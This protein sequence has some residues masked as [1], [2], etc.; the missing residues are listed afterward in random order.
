MQARKKKCY[1]ND[2]TGPTHKSSQLVDLYSRQAL[3]RGGA[4]Q[5]LR[6]QWGQD[7]GAHLMPMPLPREVSTLGSSGRSLC[8]LVC[9]MGTIMV[10]TS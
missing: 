9:T 2:M 6:R 4:T 10:L 5:C 7:A 8:L 3:L 1:D